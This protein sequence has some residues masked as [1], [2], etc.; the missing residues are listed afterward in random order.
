MAILAC[1]TC[2]KLFDSETTEAMPF[3]S[4][5]CQ[6]VDLGRWLDEEHGIPYDSAM[7]GDEDEMEQY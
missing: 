4:K 2:E 7:D 5:R 1:P 3:C 6:M